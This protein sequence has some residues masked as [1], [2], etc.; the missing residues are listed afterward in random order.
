MAVNKLQLKRSAVAGKQPTTSSLALGELAINTI[1]G[2]VFLKKDN[3]VETIVQLA[4]VSGSILSA[5]YA[6]TSSHSNNFTVTGP[7]NVYGSQYISGSLVVGND[8][9][10]R[11]L[12]VQTIT[13]SVIY[14]SG[15]NVF[16]DATSD[17]Q[18]FTGSVNISGSLN[19]V[20]NQTI[21]GS[22]IQGLEGNIATGEY[23]HAEG[24]ITK[25]IGDYSHAEG[26]NTQAVGNYSHAE[27]QDTIALGQYSHAEGFN[28]IASANYQHVQGQFNATSSVPAA[29]IVG[30]GT[31]DGNRSNLIYAAG[32]EVGITGSLNLVGNQN[33]NAGYELD[34]DSINVNTITDRSGGTLTLGASTSSISGFLTVNNNISAS[35][36]I[37]AAS[38]TGS[39]SGSI[40]NFQGT[41]TH[42]P[43]F[44]SSQVLANSA[45]YQV[46][47]AS[48]AINQDNV[49]TAAPEALYVYQPSTTSY[50]V[51]SGK[52]N[53]D[54]YLQLNIQNTNQGVSASSDVVATAN[55]GNETTNYIDMGINSEN[56]NGPIGDANDAYLYS[57]GQNLHIGNT[58]AGKHLGF[59]VGGDN[60]ETD[61]KL[62]LNPTGHHQMTGSLDID[63]QVTSSRF[64]TRGATA[65]QFVKGDGSLDS[66]VYISASIFNVTTG[67]LNDFSASVLLATS[68]LYRATASLYNATASIYNA[69]ASLYAYTA[70]NNDVISQ[71]YRETSSLN[72]ATA[73]L[74]RATASLYNA[75][76]SLY[77]FSASILNY[78][79]S[80]NVLNGTYATT[81]SN[82]FKGNQVISGS[83]T[84]SG[85]TNI[86]GTTNLTGS[87]NVS[88]STGTAITANVDTIVFTGSYAQSGSVSL[89]SSVDISGS[90]TVQGRNYINDS[91]SF[92][93]RTLN[94]E[95]TSVSVLLATASLYAATASIYNATASLYNFSASINAQTASF[96]AFSASVN[97]YTSS[98]NAVVAQLYKET[99][100]LREATASLYTATASIY[101]TTQSLYEFS[102][103]INTYTSSNN[104]V[105]AQ[106]YNETASLKFASASINLA[107]ASLY[108]FSASI[109][110]YT[111]SNNATIAQL[112][113][114]TASL[115]A[116]TASL[117]LATQSL[118]AATASLYNATA[119]LYAASASINAFSAS[120]L[121]Y[122]ASQNILNGTF[123]TTGSNTFYGT[124]TVS[125]S[126]LV[127]GSI[128][129]QGNQNIIGNLTV[130]DTITAQKLVV[131]TISSSVIFSSGSNV[132]GDELTDIQSF[133][134]S[135]EITGSLTVNG[136][137]YINDSSSFSIR[138]FNLE[139]T[140]A[141]ILLAT[142][143]LYNA[144]S[145]LYNATASLYNAT[146]SI[147]LTTES[148]Y[149]FSASINTYTASNN[150]IVAELYRVTA[151]MNAATASIYNATASLYNFSASINA[152]TASNNNVITQLYNETASLKAATASI[153]LST[154]SLNRAT[155]SIYNATA[156]L[157]AFSASI[158]AYTSSNNDVVAQ[159]YNETA[160]IKAATSSL[161]N[162]SASILNYT[163]SNNEAIADIRVA[164]ASLYAF[165]ASINSYTAS[166]NAT[167][168]DIQKATASLYN[169]T[170]SLYAASASINAFSASILA[171]TASQNILNGTYATTGSN[172]FR[173]T[174]TITGSLL[175][176]G[177]T[178]LTNLTASGL[179]YPTADGLEGQ[180]VQTDGAGNLFFNDIETIYEAIRNGESFTLAK[181]TPVYV[182]GSQGAN[183]IVY[184]A[185]AADPAKMPVIYVVAEDLATNTVGRG[186]LLGL[187]T[188]IDLTGYA[189]G[190]DV[191][192]A[193]GGGWTTTRPTGSATIQL[194]GIVTKPGNGGQGIILNP[195]PATLPNIQSGYTWIGNS[196]SYPTAI[197]TSSIQ[198]VVSSSY[199]TF[200]Q[201]IASG[202]NITASNLSVTNNAAIGG[203][204]VVNGTASFNY[205]ETIS[206]SAVIIGQEYIILN[207]QSPAARFAGLKIYDSGSTSAT[208]SIA[209]DSQR[210]HLVYQN[211]SGSSYTGGGFMSGP[212]NTGSLG[213]ETYP[214]FNRILR[215]QGGDH[216]YD[217][218]IFDNNTVIRLEIDT[219]VTGSL[220]VTNGITGSLLGTASYATYAVLAENA[221]NA[222]L[223]D[224]L[225]STE[226]VLTSSFSAFSASINS[227]TASNNANVTQLYNET[228]SL[229]VA[230]AS[231]YNFSASILNYTSS[232][233]ATISD[234]QL[235]TASL[236]AFSSSINNYTASNNSAIADIRVATASL[237]AFS[238]SMNSYTASNNA[239]IAQLYAET[240]S[241]L[242]HTASINAFSASI[243][244]YTSSN[245]DAIT[246]LYNATA[247]LNLATASLYAATASIYN[248]TASLSSSI[249]ILSG[250][251][252]SASAS[253]DTRINS[254]TE[255]V[256]THVVTNNGASNYIIDGVA[257]PILSF[258]PGATYR[259]D[260]TAVGGSHPFRFSTSPNGPT[261]YTAGVISG[262]NYI[263]IEVNYDTP[264]PLYYYCTIHSG[265]G[266]E[267]NV[268]RIEN[269]VTTASF[270][271]FSSSI[272]N[273][274]ASNNAAIA[275]ILLETASLNN[276]SA[277]ILNYTASQNILNGKYATT[278]S[279]TFEGVQTINSNLIVTGSI[280]AQTLVVQTITSSVDFVTGSTHFGTI[281]S[282]THEFTGSVSVSGSLA[283]NGSNVI[284]TNQ[285]SSMSVAT[286]S[287]WS[288][289][290]NNVLSA[291]F[292]STASY[293]SGSIVNV[294][295][296]SFADNANNAQTA[297]FVTLAQTASYVQNAQSASYW[298]GSIT[299]AESASFS[300]TASYWSGSIKNALNATFASTASYIQNAVSA[301][302]ATFAS[303][304]SFAT[305]A[306]YAAN[307][308]SGG[309]GGLTALYI[310]DEGNLQGTASYL[311]FTGDGVTA[312]VSDGTASLYIPGGGGGAGQSGGNAIYPQ[313]VAATTWS[314]THN[315]ATQYPVFTIF[316]S[317]D[318]VIIPQAIH[319]VN[320]SSALIYFSTPRTGTAV[321]SKGG[322]ITSASYALVANSAS[323]AST[324]TSASY[325]LIATSASYAATSSYSD[326]FRVAGTLTA[327]TLVV[328]TVT[329]SVIY[330][331]GSNVFGNDISNTQ[332][333]TGSVNITGSLSVDGKINS[334]LI[335]ASGK[336]LGSIGDI[337]SSAYATNFYGNLTGTAT[338]ASY[339]SGSIVNA[340][341]AS[342]VT[343]AQTASF[344]Q[345]A[346]TASFVTLAQ[347]ASFVTT[348]QT[349]SYWS[350]SIQNAVSAAFADFA[351]SASY[352]LT[353]SYATYA[354]NGGGGGGISA[355][356]IA[357]EG[358]LLGS[359]S[360]FDFSGA[361]VTAAVSAGTASFTITGGGSAGAAGLTT[362]F[363]QSVASTT[364][365]FNH[366]L[367]TR[368]P[369]VQ[370]YDTS[371]NQVQPQYVSSSNASTVEI[372]FGIATAGYAVA[373][374]GGTLSVTGSNVVYN[375]SSAA[376]TW[377][378]AHN[379]NNQYPIFQVFNTDNEVIV[380]ERIVAV[381]STSS[382]IYFPTPV[383]GRAVAS[384]G[385][386]S[387][388]AGSGAGFPFSG[389]AVI[390]GSFLVSGSFVD[391]TQVNSFTGNLTGNL[392]GTASYASNFP[393]YTV[394]FTQSVA[395]TTWSFIH[396]L[397]TR[398]PIVQVY[399]SDFKQLLPNE[400]VGVDA[401]TVE[402]RFD[403]AESG[404]AV[405]S[406]GG[407][408]YVT[409]S[410]STLV[411]SSPAVTW[412]F[413]HNLNSKYPNFEVYDTN[414]Y[415]IIPAG[416][417]AIDNN[418]AELHFATLQAGRAI[419][420]FSGIDGMSNALSASYA[421]SSS[422]FHVDKVVMDRSLMDYAQVNSSIVGSNNM[423][424]QA[425][426]SYTSMFVNYTVSNSTNARSGQI[427]AVWNG[428]TAEYNDVSTADIGDTSAVTGSVSIV[429][430][431]A[432]LNFQTNT[433]AWRIKSTATFM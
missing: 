22:L 250:S 282:N 100:S 73:S 305:T 41:A 360:Y 149:N 229:K 432:Q 314:F 411:Q 94:L 323:Y 207:T 126:V 76:A 300:S 363:T 264:T 400:I 65:A 374:M 52:G 350:G 337:W 35:G 115:K 27:G 228:A 39:F 296:A 392:N 175:V 131:Q 151:S 200:A 408:L 30:N 236:Y 292:A 288:G 26:D 132:F 99:A 293:W 130:T 225:D 367:N 91:S 233:N 389:S 60:H 420:N 263:Q 276:F 333:L 384:V 121:S 330:S 327:Q 412:S 6:Q 357:D 280:T 197:A 178:N 135:V 376:T 388:S 344:V 183:P 396:S 343:T 105:I 401:N 375:Q 342:F 20:G 79:A 272:L 279:N 302:F 31:D 371:F 271:A 50:N 163:A 267:I 359:A 103:S 119:S 66:T 56:F 393:A 306:S 198:N 265:M 55:N 365:T 266:N 273:Y 3:G 204:L 304:A 378:F 45:I 348:A 218:N 199:S 82:I 369:L 17:T 68:S 260:T 125:G 182:S 269:L 69:T 413:A 382:L 301:A 83:L 213:D 381:S 164:T 123:A 29:F 63:S 409:G 196:N 295:S 187:I 287:Y 410:T 328:Q 252:L 84:V 19:L 141:S 194:L 13:S 274:T 209:W 172:V 181:G 124:E 256:F 417:R 398:N 205:V 277:S 43:Y 153:N 340:E 147:Y 324:A 162:F 249:A 329:S 418:T 96:N 134:G 223:L 321:A 358:I 427:I 299:N 240:A 18:T 243:N 36:R 173:G 309:G 355:I 23:S 71:L 230:T 433:S 40:N 202:L 116:S 192:V 258:V 297:S 242:A 425:T 21:T 25:A 167:V 170:A 402:V 422:V 80:Q 346:Q 145:S 345:T 406:N 214:S 235:A 231:L 421:A 64:V 232:T 362:T 111:A 353:A 186:V 34:V 98:N 339:W 117:N 49:T 283:I 104:A 203:N 15:S 426:G 341:T 215:G 122:T 168:L 108:N 177:S 97:S 57:T 146:A 185:D 320:T 75:T 370:V 261:Q 255:S 129:L 114:E 313:T 403:Y 322:D 394:R 7:V 14:S 37:E 326:N 110:S 317:N 372:G 74:Y 284:L 331:S 349:A 397:N 428:G 152:Y 234:I 286:A 354:A 142:A 404:Y 429:S 53:L 95:Q 101:L 195:G 70:S 180:T 38:F 257:K 157:Y 310:L 120:I 154:E 246:S 127:S 220:T 391:F 332:T 253:F 62:Q 407:G 424:T 244:A 107:T 356:S 5:S 290:I 217:S 44:S 24:S 42:I 224:G 184:A 430:G 405:L 319:A 166:N 281:S 201:T 379:L 174:Q 298:S 176:T 419:A 48:I 259:F 193:A 54:N 61:K 268:L 270:N 118:Y 128:A 336:N 179:R 415:V 113:A 169:A 325:S 156:S 9:T 315:L 210:N 161:Y 4:D 361:G 81:G 88:G 90:L 92:S 212:R 216:L 188:G 383:A 399:G 238:A 158:N 112:Y 351:N 191:Y 47:S 208:A 221:N 219:E 86:F 32:N 275:D 254:L 431:E 247:S 414:D 77:A 89:T 143:S 2:K 395:A 46:S 338:T 58:T 106:L 190:A 10:A 1:D 239:T 241:I 366:S 237:Y 380:P 206:G 245:N 291:S 140:S 12:V 386:M 87:V 165:S 251:F 385:G 377:S 171:Y 316:D 138:T 211:A 150:D 72:N 85:S 368:F 416:I 294:L 78:T 51:I 28:T 312:T 364:W 16:G 318:D 93:T 148:L 133:T 160:S 285:T 136:R 373:S 144:T 33:I 352:S 137:N 311:N 390:T 102:A 303:S 159:L 248:T 139:Q 227:Y 278:G 307:A 226:F 289:S 109:N 59:F 347:T 67:S 387:G 334:D 335:P 155:A 189:A 308:G 262:S 8:I 11:R 423:F 222:Y